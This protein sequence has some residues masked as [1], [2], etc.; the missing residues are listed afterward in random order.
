M[1]ITRLMILAAGAERGARIPPTL[2]FQ[3]RE[4]RD[5]VD[6]CRGRPVRQGLRS[7]FVDRQNAELVTYWED[8]RYRFR[9]TDDWR[10]RPTSSSA[11]TSSPGARQPGQRYRRSAALRPLR[12]SSREMEVHLDVHQDER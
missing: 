11:I 3:Q 8:T 5:A 2:R 10:T 1:N 9:E 12:P 7:A 4:A 6:H